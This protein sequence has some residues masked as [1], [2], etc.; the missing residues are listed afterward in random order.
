MDEE[1]MDVAIAT[2]DFLLHLLSSA[3]LEAFFHDLASWLRL[4][5][6]FLT[7]IRSRNITDLMAAARPPLTFRS[8]PLVKDESKDGSVSYVHVAYCEAYEES[9][10]LL[11]TTCQYQ[12]LDAL[13]EVTRS[14][15][16]VL[17]QRVHKTV[18]IRE[19]AALAGFALVEHTKRNCTAA[20]LECDLGGSF[21]FRY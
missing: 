11:E 21:E 4:G 18:E 13:G 15:F 1:P 8:C 12:I 7:D 3:E 5:A 10:Q 16:R 6:R 19:A 14:Y 20:A 9:T 17:R 2:D